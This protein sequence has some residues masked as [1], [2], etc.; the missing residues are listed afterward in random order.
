MAFRMNFGR[1]AAFGVA[2]LAVG[3]AAEVASD[4]AC[5]AD[6]TCEQD[7][8]AMLQTKEQ[9]KAAMKT[10][11][12][13][14]SKDIQNAA[15]VDDLDLDNFLDVAFG[16]EAGNPSPEQTPNGTLGGIWYSRR[17]RRSQTGSG[18]GKWFTQA[19]FDD[20]FPETFPTASNRA[21][22]GKDFYTYDAFIEAAAA[23]PEFAN[24]GDD[25]TDRLELAAFL[26]Q[27]SH[28]TTGGWRTAPGGP[29]AWGYCFKEEQ[30]CQN[31]G[32]TQYCEAGNPCAQYGYDCT[33]AAGQ[34]YFGRGPFQLSWNYN[35]A[36]ASKAILGDPSILVND[37]NK[38]ATD[39]VLA[40]KTALWFWMTPQSPKPS[41]HAVMAGT[42][43]PTAQD[44]AEGRVPGYG[45]VTNIINGGIECDRPTGS[46][47]LNRV[48]FYLRFARLL[49]VYTRVNFRTNFCNR[50][51]SY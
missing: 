19:D 42:W 26:G 10:T 20:F 33:C 43:V 49:N 3:Q 18:I 31:G 13:H 11:N 36:P 25:T 2:A 12:R 16:N 27:S 41:C 39:A 23:Y 17:R 30:G 37:P 22:T 28:E 6:G 29:Y 8:A 14:P 44:R 5:M 48:G 45:M 15:N 47:T 7:A 24:S 34:E 46:E 9:G 1:F 40:Y 38:V 50:M 51:T 21:C 35:Y 32:C 4:E